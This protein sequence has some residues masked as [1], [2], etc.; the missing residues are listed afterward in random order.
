MAPTT[1]SNGR[2]SFEVCL[3]SPGRFYTFDLA[4]QL[5]AHGTL[6]RMYTGYPIWKVDVTHSKVRTFPWLLGL[7]TRLGW[8]LPGPI[9]DSLSRAVIGTFDRWMSSRLERCDVF[10]C[11][12]GFGVRSH[13]QAKSRFGAMT[14]CDR[15]SS[16]I[17]NQDEILRQE[18]E[19]W[20]V[21]YRPID[22]YVVDR[23]EL[24]YDFCDR[25]V[26][27]STFAYRTFIEMKVPQ[28]KVFKVPFGVDLQMFHRKPKHDHKFR[29]IYVGALSLRKGVGY[30]LDAV[31]G[32]KNRDIE[33]WLIGSALPEVRHILEKYKS[34]YRYFGVVPRAKLSELYSQGSVFVIAS[35]EEGLA[36]VQAQ[37][38]ACGLPIIGTRNSGA[39]DLLDDGIEGFIVPIRDPEALREKLLFLYEKPKICEQMAKAALKRVQSAGG[40]KDYGQA[41]MKAYSEATQSH[42]A[43]EQCE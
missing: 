11:I 13:Q 35:V 10:H 39:E 19:R 12:S 24:E 9:Q 14:V 17:R 6:K 2:N 31:A 28:S 42:A 1:L 34:L 41:M 20:N 36:L 8:R 25:I 29:V 26:V 40:W 33:V 30:L 43:R 5:E 37:A 21:P 38:M 23:E 7:S 32:L 15:G 3:G 27:P 16:H 4:R 22:T 18:H